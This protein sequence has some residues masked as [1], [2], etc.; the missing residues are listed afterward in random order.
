MKILKYI[1]KLIP[2]QKKT[3]IKEPLKNILVV[4][5]TGFGD[6]ILTTP[7]IVSLRKSFPNIDITFLINDKYYK[8]FEDFKYVNRLIKYKSGFFNQL[9]LIKQLRTLR[10]DTIFLF[11]SNG[12][13]DIFFSKL[14]GATRLLKMTYNMNHE[15]KDIFLNKY[16]D[17]VQH[18]VE[19]RLDLIRIFNP[20]IIVTRLKIPNKFYNQNNYFKDLSKVYIA[21]QL[22]AQDSFK[23]WPVDNFVKLAE[24]VIETFPQVMIVILGA[25]SYERKLTDDFLL[26]ISHPKNVIDLC[27]KTNIE[28]L[29]SIL[30]SC[31]VLVTNDT[32]TMHLSI[33][34]RRSTIC[35]FGPTN[36]K[37]F[38]PY[39]DIDL[40][41][42]IQKNIKIDTSSFN[43]KS[44][45]QET[46]NQINIEEVYPYIEKEIG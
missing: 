34:L 39:Q 35:L 8:L 21:F 30:N 28:V 9:I 41:T 18:D 45:S 22:G 24:M 17:K 5:N 27:S 44:W 37:I 42:I 1:N 29:P 32:G 12:P 46:M 4:S 3:N 43:K 7:S 26:K 16:V 38:G 36:S 10:I 23:M 25:T 33:A 11:H 15:Y 13:E 40:H 19:N 14:S 31:K 6:T 20:N 2:F